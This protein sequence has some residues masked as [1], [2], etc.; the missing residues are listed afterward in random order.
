[1]GSMKALG[2]LGKRPLGYEVEEKRWLNYSF[3]VKPHFE[4]ILKRLSTICTYE[5]AFFYDKDLL[6]VIKCSLYMFLFWKQR[7]L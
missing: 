6:I 3:T 2:R 5:I 7:M 1:M 4:W